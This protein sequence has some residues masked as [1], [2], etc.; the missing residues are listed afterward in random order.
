MAYFLSHIG[1]VTSSLQL[2]IGLFFFG[3]AG[4]LCNISI[5]SQGIAVEQ[6]YGRPIMA[7]FHGGWS[8]AGFTGA[9]IGL[10]MI[11]LHVPPS[12]HFIIVVL[13]VSFIVW[14]NHPFLLENKSES[15]AGTGRRRFFRKPEGILL[16]L[17]IIGFCSMASEGP[18]STGAAYISRM[19]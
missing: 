17:G 11:N 8:L 5:N 12:W 3:L 4:N 10:I 18:C 13:M 6:L 15:R 1:F 2:T 9:L 19:W 16:Q 7:S 14:F